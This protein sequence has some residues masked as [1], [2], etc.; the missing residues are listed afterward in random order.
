MFSL[1]GKKK[2]LIYVKP[3]ASCEYGFAEARTQGDQ[4]VRQ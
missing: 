1:E 2:Q 3:Q 4:Q